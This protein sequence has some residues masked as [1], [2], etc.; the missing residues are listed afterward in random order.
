[1]LLSFSSIHVVHY[2]TC[3][4]T[5]LAFVG[6][7][8]VVITF[9]NMYEYELENGI[10]VFYLLSTLFLIFPFAAGSSLRVHFFKVLRNVILPMP[11]E[12]YLQELGANASSSNC[13][14]SISI[15]GTGMLNPILTSPKTSSKVV[16]KSVSPGGA[17]SMENSRSF[18]FNSSTSAVV[19]FEEILLADALCS[20]SKIFKD[21]GTT[22]IVLYA[23]LTDTA[24]TDYHYHGMILIAILASFPFM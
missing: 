4:F 22:I 19:P 14:Q 16:S 2:G 1:M 7:Y 9:N 10:L 18:N 8:S 3:F 6:L 12:K 20:L 21:I 23:F 24:V 11:N 5:A 17:S 15:G 13:A